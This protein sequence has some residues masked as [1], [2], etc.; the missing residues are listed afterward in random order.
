MFINSHFICKCFFCVALIFA[1]AA[2]YQRFISNKLRQEF[3]MQGVPLRIFYR[4]S[5]ASTVAH[6]SSRANSRP[7]T[8]KSTTSL[9][10]TTPGQKSPRR[11]ISSSGGSFRDRKP[12]VRS[13]A[14]KSGPVGDSQSHRR[15][16]VKH[17][18]SSTRLSKKKTGVHKHRN[19]RAWSK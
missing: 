7:P 6:I 12:V 13:P 2:S 9:V 10:S 3:Q 4:D 8:L 5:G 14:S 11:P 16:I 18:G 17:G 15:V 19:G 1:V